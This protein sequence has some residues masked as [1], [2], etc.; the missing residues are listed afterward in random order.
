MV[1]SVMCHTL[2]NGMLI[3]L[4]RAETGVSLLVWLGCLAASPKI[5]GQRK[6][7]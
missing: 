4:G 5:R 1:G 3:D 6:L 7:T 2:A